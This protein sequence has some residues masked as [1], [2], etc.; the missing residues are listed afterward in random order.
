MS[1]KGAAVVLALSLVAA[2]NASIQLYL[3]DTGVTNY[4][5]DPAA[6]NY[7]PYFNPAHASIP[8]GDVV[9]TNPLD[10]TFFFWGKFSGSDDPIGVQIFGIA[11]FVSVT[12][13]LTVQENLIYRH[14]K[15]NGATSARWTRW[16]GINPIPINGPAAAVTRNGM[17]NDSANSL[18]DLVGSAG[19]GEGNATFLVGAFRV[20]STAAPVGAIYIGLGPLGLAARDDVRSYYPEVSVGDVGD[21]VLVQP[22][23]YDPDP[24][25]PLPGTPSTSGGVRYLNYIVPEPAGFLLLGLVGLVLRRR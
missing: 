12:G 9:Q 14:S 6:R 4:I 23:W 7:L 8:M 17:V 25:I 22:R 13:N 5:F 11:P 3:Q 19:D 20:T 24:N 21:P 16:D 2:A 18:T 15:T 1:R 10:R